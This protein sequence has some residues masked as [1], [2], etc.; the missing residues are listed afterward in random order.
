LLRTQL[1]Q[2]GSNFT[3]GSFDAAS[4]TGANSNANTLF[5][6]PT[7]TTGSKRSVN[8]T[9]SFTGEDIRQVPTGSPQPTRCSGNLSGGGY[10]C[11]A[12]LVLPQAVGQSNDNRTAYLRL[13]PLYNTTHFRVTLGD[14]AKFS[15]IQPSIDSTGR[16]NDL[17]RRVESRV[18][19]VDTAFPYPEATVDLTGDLCK[20]FVVTDTAGQAT[21]TCTP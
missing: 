17:Y 3:L 10:A 21:S 5:L 4:S 15:G 16:A 6:Y 8:D 1:M 19:L 11:R 2:F 20:D 12:T 9:W 18:D 7:G 13:T 14:G